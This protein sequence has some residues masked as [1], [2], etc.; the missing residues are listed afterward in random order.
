MRFEIKTGLFSGSTRLR[1]WKKRKTQYVHVFFGGKTSGKRFSRRNSLWKI[2]G[3]KR[4]IDLINRLLTWCFSD[5]SRFF[6]QIFGKMDSNAGKAYKPSFFR[7]CFP[8]FPICQPR[9]SSFPLFLSGVS[10]VFHIS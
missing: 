4:W 6:I 9:F 3:L 7:F 8:V 10:A 5:V 2:R 1:L